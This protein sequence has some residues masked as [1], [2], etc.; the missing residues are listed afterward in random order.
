VYEIEIALLVNED[1]PHAPHPLMRFR[2]KLW[3]NAAEV[4]TRA[5]QY[6]SN[7]GTIPPVHMVPERDEDPITIGPLT[8]FE[9]IFEEQDLN[10]RSYVH[11]LFIVRD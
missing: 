3:Q 5:A 11:T 8:T 6:F 4:Q 9:D 7:D 2:V 10:D 1:W